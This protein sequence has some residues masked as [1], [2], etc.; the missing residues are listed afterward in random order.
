MIRRKNW[1]VK[2]NTTDAPFKDRVLS[3]K[4][5]IKESPIHDYIDMIDIDIAI[6]QGYGKTQDSQSLRRLFSKS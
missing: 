2:K 5:E 6:F 3:V 4:G 1:N